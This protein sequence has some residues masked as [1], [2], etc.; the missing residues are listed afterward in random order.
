[1]R[2]NIYIILTVIFLISACRCN[3]IDPELEGLEVLIDW[4]KFHDVH[5]IYLGT[6]TKFLAAHHFYEK[7][8]F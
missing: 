7:S 2:I 3:E 8:G 4:C 1:M 6:T 5:E